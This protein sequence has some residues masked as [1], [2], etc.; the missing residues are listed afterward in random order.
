ML[1]GTVEIPYER[2]AADIDVYVRQDCEQCKYQGIKNEEIPLLVHPK[3]SRSLHSSF[4]HATI[5]TL[6]LGSVDYA[7]AAL[8]DYVSDI[9]HRVI[10]RRGHVRPVGIMDREVHCNRGTAVYGSR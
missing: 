4:S 5:L 2:L 7:A 1:A 10:V 6:R 3:K 8:D 9:S